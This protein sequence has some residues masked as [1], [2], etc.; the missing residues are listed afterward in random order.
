M[1]LL[2]TDIRNPLTNILTEETASLNYEVELISGNKRI[3]PPQNE[4][5]IKLDVFV[6]CYKV[7][8]NHTYG[9]FYEVLE[10]QGIRCDDIFTVTDMKLIKEDLVYNIY[11]P[12]EKMMDW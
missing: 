11:E 8:D 12:L 6:P 5:K 2:Y 3:C 7:L 1:K 9:K 10:K 4:G